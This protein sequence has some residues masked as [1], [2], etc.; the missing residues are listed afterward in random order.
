MDEGVKIHPGEFICRVV[1]ES[2][3]DTDRDGES[4]FFYR[5]VDKYN[6]LLALSF[7][8]LS[9]ISRNL[10]VLPSERVSPPD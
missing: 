2:C 5:R 9:S 3:I 4:C 10:L 8:F 1:R 7:V 6:D